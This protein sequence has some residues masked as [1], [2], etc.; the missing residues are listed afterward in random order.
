MQGPRGGHAGH[1]GPVDRTELHLRHVEGDGGGLQTGL[2]YFQRTRQYGSHRA[3]TSGREAR[4]GEETKNVKNADVTNEQRSKRAS[5]DLTRL[6]R[7]G[8]KKAT[9]AS[10]KGLR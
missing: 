9:M 7:V 4:D 5:A 3:P 10:H 1:A 6:A 2:H 8:A